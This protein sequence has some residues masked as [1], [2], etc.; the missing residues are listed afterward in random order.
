MLK[1][2]FIQNFVL[3]DSLDIQF[4]GGFSVITG[5]TGAGKSIILG[6]LSLVLGQ[7]ADGKSIKNG[8]DKCIIEAVF[9]I[10]KYQLE[11]FFQENDL[12]YDHE[13]CILRRELFASGKS[14][15]FINDSPVALPV[16]KELG[17]RL[18]DIHSQH[19]N[20]LL[21]DNRFQ[22]KVVDVM[23]E[24]EILLILYRKEYNR[25]QSLQKELKELKDKAA[26]TKQEEDYIRF[27]LEQLSEA[28]LIVG[29]QEDLEQ[30]Q[31]TLSHAEEIKSSLYKISELLNGDEMGGLQYIKEALSTADSLE[32]YF[33]KAKDISERLRSAYID[34]NDLASETDTMR[35]DV[36]FNPE[37]LEWVNE[38]L[39][40]IYSLQQKH[41]VSTVEELLD[42]QSKYE[43]QLKEIDSFEEQIE[44]L[45]KQSEV[46]Y[47][48]L[49][50]QASVL[51]NQRK[52]A[53]KGMAGQLVDMIIPLGM[54]N[55]RF[56][57]DVMAKEEPDNDGMDD[58]RF[59]FSA[60]KSGDLQPVAQTASGGEISRLM[61]CLKAMIAG[62]TALPTIIFDEVDTGVS[63][64]IADKMG[65]I[66][67][68]LGT[69]MQ[70][71]AI[72][73]LPQIAAKGKEHYFVYKEDT[74][75]RTITRIKQL[76]N[77]ER[78]LEVARMLSGASLTEA[79]MANA[80]ELL[81]LKTN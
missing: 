2:L 28:R 60:N 57:V 47:K 51:S 42:I 80:R 35:E 7:R 14:R 53:A 18:I 81:H 40:T 22:L 8:A 11:S 10:S 25:F 12:E 37:R 39:N 72:T 77:E 23:A 5:E 9:D 66:M 15:A 74:S 30:E 13:S 68:D 17:G 76:T 29:E 1:S 50:Q 61:L 78:I 79:S 48:E 56:R 16:M 45:S 58:I 44:S 69:K 32:H 34:L 3:I 73:H 4:D 31:E 20:L 26:Q 41:H 71:F 21:G 75:D 52:I 63:G 27:Q 62:F 38:R 6:A 70:V 46:S 65:D 33:S 55:T 59:M 36:E 64:D 54:P 43:A 49:L 19:Q 67:Q 24:N